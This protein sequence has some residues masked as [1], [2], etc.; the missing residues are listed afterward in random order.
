M[1]AKVG[2]V[3]P[4]DRATDET[5][6][7]VLVVVHVGESDEVF[8][9]ERGA[10]ID[11]EGTFGEAKSG[12]GLSLGDEGRGESEPGFAMAWLADKKVLEEQGGASRIA[13]A[14]CFE[15]WGE[16]VHG[17]A[18]ETLSMTVFQSPGEV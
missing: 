8:L 13:T 3:G 1:K 17:S 15:G 11:G 7:E 18:A 10:R 6:R 14:K 16:R 4:F 2:V 5:K 9:D 12:F